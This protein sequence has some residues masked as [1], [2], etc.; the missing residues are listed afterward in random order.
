MSGGPEDEARAAREAAG[1]RRFPDP[2]DMRATTSALTAATALVDR[3]R[4]L[5]DIAKVL[6]VAA[7]ASAEKA[8]TT[9]AGV[10]GGPLAQ[11]GAEAA[12]EALRRATGRA[13]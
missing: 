9:A 11:L 6:L 2:D 10:F 3:D 1:V 12:F 5:I 8:A 13:S 4:H 7:Q